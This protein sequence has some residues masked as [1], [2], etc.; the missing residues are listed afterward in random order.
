MRYLLCLVGLLFVLSGCSAD[1]TGVVTVPPDYSHIPNPEL[2]WAAYDL[3]DYTIVQTRACECLP[4]YEYTII[5]RNGEAVDVEY[6]VD[7]G[8]PVD[9]FTPEDAYTVEE[10]FDVIQRAEQEGAYSIGVEYDAR[11]GYPTSVFIDYDYN[12]ADEELILTLSDL[13]LLDD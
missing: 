12:I 7:D 11:F 8:E 9:D 3:D 2:R 13:Q 4:P 10:L 5:V 1:D 6:D